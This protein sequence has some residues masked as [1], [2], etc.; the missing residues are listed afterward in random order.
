MPIY[1]PLKINKMDMRVTGQGCEYNVRAVPY[2]D[3]GLADNINKI[4]TNIKCPGNLV[5]EILQTGEN[6]L[7]AN[8]NRRVEALEE[9]NI[10]PGYDRYVVAFP[11]NRDSIF[12]IRNI[13]YLK[14]FQI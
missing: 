9:S 8:M 6:S 14:S 11:K 5:H 2:T 13:Y 3:L 1:L 12:S 4:M 10:I 7:T